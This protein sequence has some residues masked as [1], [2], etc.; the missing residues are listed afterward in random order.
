MTTVMTV[1]TNR[2]RPGAELRAAIYA[3]A[4]AMFRKRGY[5]AASVNEIV[6]A[7]GVAKGTFFNFFPTK[8]HVLKAYYAEIDVE[9]ARLRKKLDPDDPAGSLERYARGVERILRREGGLMLDLLQATMSDPAMRAMD[10]D[11]G[12]IDADEFADFLRRAITAETLRADIDVN[13]ATAAL[14][15]LW[16]G[17]VR[18]W[19]ANPEDSSLAKLFGGRLKLLFEGIST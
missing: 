2:S 6:A 3:A 9:I 5:G 1:V 7:A 8:A 19:M 17:A 16:A 18:A 15:D 4:I 10:E 11:S 12:S 14:M 13:A